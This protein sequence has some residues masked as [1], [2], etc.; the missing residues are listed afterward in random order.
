[1]TLGFDTQRRG[2]G[3]HQTPSTGE[4]F[5][6]QEKGEGLYIPNFIMFYSRAL[7]STDTN[8]V[9]LCRIIGGATFCV[10]RALGF[11]RTNPCMMY[12]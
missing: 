2:G 3:A 7:L 4:C 1:M 5:D 6:I 10:S 8:I 9:D 11:L 12:E